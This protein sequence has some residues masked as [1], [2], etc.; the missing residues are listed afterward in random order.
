[1]QCQC[2]SET[3]ERKSVSG[4]FQLTYKQCTSC[5]RQGSYCLSGGFLQDVKGLEAKLMFN[6]LTGSDSGF[7]QLPQQT[8]LL[9]NH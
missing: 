9:S 3:T 1:M 4:Q 8:E 2:G 5:M 6:K 7:P